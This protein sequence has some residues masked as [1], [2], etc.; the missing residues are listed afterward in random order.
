MYCIAEVLVFLNWCVLKN[1]ILILEM[2]IC[3]CPLILSLY[4]QIPKFGCIF[5][6]A[7][8]CCGKDNC[9]DWRPPEAAL[10]CIRA[11]SDFV[12][13]VEAEIMPQV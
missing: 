13:P 2:M 12:P 10:Y 6:Q 9:T 7:L 4:Y 3:V 8:S 11:I 1:S 5:S